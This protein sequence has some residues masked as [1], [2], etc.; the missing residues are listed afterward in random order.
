[1]TKMRDFKGTYN[2]KK[3]IIFNASEHI[4][5]QDGTKIGQNSTHAIKYVPQGRKTQLQRAGFVL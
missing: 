4:S 3:Q 5:V 1:M 2:P